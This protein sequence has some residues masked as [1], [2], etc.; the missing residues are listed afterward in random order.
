MRDLAAAGALVALVWIA[1]RSA[2]PRIE[3]R[4]APRIRVKQQ[5]FY[6]R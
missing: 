6:V 3:I 1:V 5:L 2:R 4:T